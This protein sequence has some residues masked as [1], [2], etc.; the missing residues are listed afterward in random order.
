M[1]FNDPTPARGSTAIKYLYA[2]GLVTGPAQATIPGYT[3]AG[4]QP[5]GNQLPGVGS[6]SNVAAAN[7]NNFAVQLA[8]RAMK[9]LEEN[10]IINGDASTDALKFSGIIKLMSTTNTV[11]KNTSALSLDDVNTAVQYAFEDGG[12][13]SIAICDPATFTDLIKLTSAKIGFMQS[14]VMTEYGFSALKLNTMVG[15][16]LVV[17]SRFMTTT[18]GSKAMYF[19]DLSVWEMRVLQDMTFDKLAKTNDSESFMLK[20]YEALICRATAFNSSITEIQ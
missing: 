16:V 17:P 1:T 12:L 11:D 9:E 5:Q 18:S 10:T 2:T 8:A 20:M 3:L 4:F 6:F 15:E 19:L 7:A 13:P 14:A